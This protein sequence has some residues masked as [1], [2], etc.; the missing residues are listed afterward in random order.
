MMT[1]LE[2]RTAKLHHAN[3]PSLMSEVELNDA[4]HITRT[5]TIVARHYNSRSLECDE[6]K[7]GL[8]ETPI[9]KRVRCQSP[10][11]DEAVNKNPSRPGILDGFRDLQCQRFAFDFSR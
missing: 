9:M 10:E 4:I 1:G 7:E 8:S 2:I 3:G 11:V 5:V 6:L